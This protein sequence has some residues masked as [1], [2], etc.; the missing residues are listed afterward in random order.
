MVLIQFAVVVLR[1]VFGLG[2][3]WMQESI[4]YMHGI[5]FL[6]GAGY[7]LLKDGHV[8]VDIFYRAAHPR[9]KALVDMLGV[10]FLLIPFCA[11]V[12]TVA[13][14]YVQNSWAVFEGSKETSG[15]QAVYLLKTCILVFTVLMALQ[16]LAILMKSILVLKGA[17]EDNG[18]T[19]STERG[20]VH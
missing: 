20:G 6:V 11:L 15:I 16:G 9:T 14:P 13:L 19:T 17:L 2:F 5:V 3:I 1:Y 7:T 12:W 18:D 4:L 8:R 10:I